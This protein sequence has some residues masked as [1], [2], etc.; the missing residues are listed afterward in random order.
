MHCCPT[1]K[2]HFTLS[3]LQAQ[4]LWALLLWHLLMVFA[5]FYPFSDLLLFPAATSRPY[6]CLHV[7]RLNICMWLHVSDKCRVIGASFL[8]GIRVILAQD[9]ITNWKTSQWT[10]NHNIHFKN[11]KCNHKLHHSQKSIQNCKAKQTLMTLV[12]SQMVKW[13]RLKDKGTLWLW[14]MGLQLSNCTTTSTVANLCPYVVARI[15]RF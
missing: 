11:P 6:V 7:Y 8:I 15:F 3:V 1:A 13:T 4:K 12:Q 9:Q 5:S 2:Y 14:V 10:Y